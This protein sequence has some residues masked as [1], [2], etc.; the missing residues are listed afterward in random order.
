LT[1]GTG[2]KGFFGLPSAVGTD[3]KVWLQRDNAVPWWLGYGELSFLV[4][5]GATPAENCGMG[6]V[7]DE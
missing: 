5:V 4:A 3:P 2:F 7:L 6:A 1:F